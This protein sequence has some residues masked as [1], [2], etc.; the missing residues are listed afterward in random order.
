[1]TEIWTPGPDAAAWMAA[2]HAETFEAPWGADAFLD[3]LPRRGVTA[4]AAGW[5]GFIL[6]QAVM[7]EAEVLTLAVRPAARRRGL[8]RA[9]VEA[10]AARLTAHGV[11]VLR[12]E[13][14]QDNPAGLA[15][16]AAAGFAAV[17]VRRGYYARPQGRRVDA[18]VL[19]RRLNTPRA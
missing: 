2:V 18:Q 5:D 11:A 3:L 19:A 15:L 16:Y 17:G 6:T 7:D 12:L 4:L 14:A 10:A 13:V 8:G 1:M 9:L